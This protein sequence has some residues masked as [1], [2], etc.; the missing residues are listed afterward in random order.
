MDLAGYDAYISGKLT[1]YEMPEEE[2]S[3]YIKDLENLPKAEE[4]K[5]G[6]W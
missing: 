3:V 2:L 6:K 1:D 4:R 5:S